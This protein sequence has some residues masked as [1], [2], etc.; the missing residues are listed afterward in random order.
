M[1]NHHFRIQ[2]F[3]NLL[4]YLP[5]LRHL[6]I[7]CLDGFDFNDIEFYPIILKDLKYVSLE[8][9]LVYFNRFEKLIKN[10]FYYIEVLYIT[11]KYDS[12]YLDAERWEELISTYMPNLRIFDINHDGSVQASPFE[13]HNFINQFNSSFWFKKQWFFTHQHD[14]EE[15]LDTGIF[16]S[17][18]PYR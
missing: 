2:S 18:N 15:R 8:L 11:T 17:T 14:C 13:Y 6:S 9:E 3:N 16:Y 7:N 10:F 12:Q 1:I 4:S 5:Q